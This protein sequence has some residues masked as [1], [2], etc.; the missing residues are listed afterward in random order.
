MD[1]R[2]SLY[3]Q[4]S[5]LSGEKSAKICA[6]FVPH[7]KIAV[8]GAGQQGYT[9]LQQYKCGTHD[10]FSVDE[11]HFCK[12]PFSKMTDELADIIE[13]YPILFW[14]L[15]LRDLHIRR[16]FQNCMERHEKRHGKEKLSI[17]VLY[18]SQKAAAQNEIVDAN[19]TILVDDN[20]PSLALVL[21]TLL[22]EL[23]QPGLVGIDLFDVFSVLRSCRSMHYFRRNGKS[24]DGIEP[25][26]LRLEKDAKD[27]FSSPHPN[28]IV[29]SADTT[30]GMEAVEWV[31]D[32]FAETG[33]WVNQ[34][35]FLQEEAKQDISIS[36]LV[37][38]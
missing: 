37:G 4:D 30:H 11:M 10:I 23:S 7:F 8:I 9:A 32:T 31:I 15:D 18:Q 14:L 5:N 35:T 36:L 6:P 34:L 27:I 16:M 12:E 1:T 13:N 25:I 2:E 28:G 20:L 19:L 33:C 24:A 3:Q 29:S 21:E 22:D 26:L 38:R 17:C